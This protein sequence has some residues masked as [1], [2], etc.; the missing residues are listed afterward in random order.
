MGLR[1]EGRLRS[2]AFR[3]KFEFAAFQ[4]LVGRPQGALQALGV[5]DALPI[6]WR[7]S[8]ARLA[9]FV[10]FPLVGLLPRLP[11]LGPLLF[12]LLQSLFGFLEGALAFLHRLQGRLRFE[13]SF[14][15]RAGGLL[16]RCFALSD[17]GFVRSEC[18]IAVSEILR[19][20]VEPCELYSLSLLVALP[21]SC[22]SCALTKLVDLF[23]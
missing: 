9:G 17:A 22:L 2:R 8:L 5:L 11:S 4:R 16:R 20:G 6:L 13:G 12:R 3:F 23:L 18:G 7:S 19:S 10:E 21:F 1:L 14:R 15:C